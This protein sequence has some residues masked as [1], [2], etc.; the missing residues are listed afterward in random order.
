HS[1]SL[2]KLLRG[3]GIRRE[4]TRGKTNQKPRH[5]EWDRPDQGDWDI[6][7]EARTRVVE[8]EEN[9]AERLVERRLEHQRAGRE[10]HKAQAAYGHALFCHGAWPCAD[11]HVPAAT[12][13]TALSMPSGRGYGP[14]TA[15]NVEPGPL[16]L[17]RDQSSVVAPG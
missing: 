5:E 6:C 10:S 7:L 11:W 15:V 17:N 2:D 4:S 13:A 8:G 12:R 1:N 9:V 14:V 3:P 16:G